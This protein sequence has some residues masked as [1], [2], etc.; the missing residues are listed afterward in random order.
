MVT[1]I[2]NGCLEAQTLEKVYIIAGFSL[3][4]GKAKLLLFKRNYMFFDVLF[5]DGMKYVLIVSE[6]LDYS[7]ASCN[8]I[9]GCEKRVHIRIY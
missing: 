7:C 1:D 3:V 9:F 5:F 8:L 4:T 6:I 2:R